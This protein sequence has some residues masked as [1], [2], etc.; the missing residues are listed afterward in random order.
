MKNVSY[1]YLLILCIHLSACISENTSGPLSE[2]DILAGSESVNVTG[3]SEEIM[4]MMAGLMEGGGDDV[5]GGA[6]IGGNDMEEDMMV[7]GAEEPDMRMLPEPPP[8]SNNLDACDR[9]C[10]RVEDCIY[11]RCEAIS[12]LPPD[13]FCRGWCNNT[14]EEWLDQGADLSCEDF[15][16]RVYGFSPELRTLCETDPN[17]DACEVI[18]EFGEVC[19]LVSD[20]CLA[21]CQ[22]TSNQDQLC[23]RS[24]T[25]SND[26]RRF[27]QCYQQDNGPDD[28]RSGYEEV[29]ANL[30]EREANC[31]F[32]ACA[33]GTV[34]AG[35]VSNCVETCVRD[36]PSQEVLFERYQRTCEEVVSDTLA[37][38]SALANL[39]ELPEDQ[40]CSNLCTS[41]VVGCGEINQ[42][43]C[44]LRCATWDD[45]NYVCLRN[46]LS[47]DE[48]NECLVDEDEQDRC[49]RSCDRLQVCLEEACPPRIIPPQLTDGCT[50]DCFDDPISEDDLQEWE[51]TECRQ[52]REVVYDD[53]P[54]LRPICEGNRDF[55]PSPGECSAFCDSGLDQC[56]IG[57]RTI[58][59]SACASMTRDQ[60]ICSL[61]ANGECVEIDT[62]LTE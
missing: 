28:G 1:F 53:N 27:M 7:A 22:G 37:D 57:G 30:C 47:C 4:D 32:N 35:T 24:A 40:V 34:D 3:G 43:D 51:M 25:D 21:N 13:Q 33:P 31:V 16:R 12:Q 48:V 60:Y 11:P 44:E 19:G 46:S 61:E 6:V 52:V 17:V 10:Q 50:A 62:C 23:F 8:P 38:D 29:C 41:T 2:G 20:E 54:Q 56:I 55:R 42:S 36:E 14:G 39:C 5:V 59:L 18:C 49:R 15:S 9:F 45:A 58:C 26:C